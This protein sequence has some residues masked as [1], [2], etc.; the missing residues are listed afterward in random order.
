MDIRIC[1]TDQWSDKDW[2]TYLQS[3]N[4]VFQK[5]FDIPYFK[6]K[7][8]TSIDGYAYHS[9][10][11]N[12]EQEIVGGCTIIPVNYKKNTE[13]VKIGQAV[14]VFIIEEYRT[15]PLMLRRMYLQLKKQLIVKGFK[16]VLA[17]P[18]NIAYPFWKNIVKWKDVGNLTYWALPVKFGNVIGKWRLLN[19]LSA[20]FCYF[21]LSINE[22]M[23]FFFNNT[24][25][26]SIYELNV[27][28]EYRQSRFSL[29]YTKVIHRDIIFY[30]RIYDEE[31]VKTAYLIDVRQNG[32]F[33]FK[34]L[35]KGVSYL[36]NKT[37]SDIILYIGLMKI[38]QTL[39][40]K[41]PIK[42][43]PKR[44]PLTCDILNNED[45]EIFADMLEIKNWNFGLL[46]YDVR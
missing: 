12:Y 22:F 27:N 29:E 41:V 40:L 33:T 30:Y 8:L 31:G 37:N 32:S 39:L 44:L 43:E 17:V 35:F 45:T 4:L 9:L 1:T 42:F 34:A 25:K 10:L 13:I 20:G 46:N 14:D 28:D 18:N 2:T 15:D 6:H 5:D 16:A 36:I 38:F 21:W 19:I 26:K 3:F 11:I 23:I 7:Y 24:E